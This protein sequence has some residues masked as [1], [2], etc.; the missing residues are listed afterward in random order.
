MYQGSQSIEY[1][2]CY[3]VTPHLILCEL[4]RFQSRVNP[5][6]A[7]NF[8]FNLC[9]HDWYGDQNHYLQCNIRSEQAHR[10]HRVLVVS[11]GS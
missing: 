7:V 10:L 6:L 2:Y 9:F 1:Q 3:C 5:E 8:G 4:P 11:T